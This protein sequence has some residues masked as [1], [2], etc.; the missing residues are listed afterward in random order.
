MGRH[1]FFGIAVVALA[2]VGVAVV[3]DAA[4]GPVAIIGPALAL[5]APRFVEETATAGIDHVYGG[6]FEYAVGG[7]VAAF[8]CNGDGK[9]DLYIAGG[10]GPAGLYRNDSP[11]GGALRFTRLVDPATDLVGVNGAYPIDIDGDGVE[12]LVLLRN[13]E[14]ILLRGLGGC[15]FE[16]ANERWGF[17]GGCGKPA[18][19]CRRSRSADI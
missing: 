12:D 19:A 3:P 16:R 11:A 5:G 17:D 13:G 1:R 7:G 6:G 8:D 15:R 18:R 2:I 10:S 14:I 4:S 9:P